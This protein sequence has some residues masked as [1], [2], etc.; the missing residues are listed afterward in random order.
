MRRLGGS[1]DIGRITR[2]GGA[3][4]RQIDRRDRLK[5]GAGCSGTI[6]ATN[7]IEDRRTIVTG[8]QRFGLA[9]VFGE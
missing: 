2:C 3:D 9:E 7:M 1:G 4:Y 5:S 8:E 6:L